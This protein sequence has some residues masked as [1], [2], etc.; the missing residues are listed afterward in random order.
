MAHTYEHGSRGDSAHRVAEPREKR[1]RL[2]AAWILLA[3]FGLIGCDALEYEPS[4]ENVGDAVPPTTG[5]TVD[6]AASETITV[7]GQATL[8]YTLDLG[9]KTFVG[10]EVYLD[11]E[12]FGTSESQTAFSFASTQVPD[13][14]Y[15]LRL[16]AY[17][18]S[19]TG[20]LADQLGA[21]VVVSEVMRT[22]VVD[23]APPSPVRIL[24][25][26]PVA[27]RL[28]L[29]WSAYPRSSFQEYRVYSGRYGQTRLR[30]TLR[31]RDR[32]TWIDSLFV[33]GDVRYE[34]VVAAANGE[35]ASE[36]FVVEAPVPQ[37][38]AFE[39]LGEDGI[40][41]TWSASRFPGNV[42]RYVIERQSTSFGAPWEAAAVTVDGRDTV[43]VDGVGDVFA[44]Q[45]YYRIRTEAADDTA[46]ESGGF[47]AWAEARRAVRD[48]VYLAASDAFVGFQVDE[49]DTRMGL[50][51]LDAQ[52]LDVQAER[53]FGGISYAS[54]FAPRDGTRLFTMEDGVVRERDPHT[55]A[56]VRSLNLNTLLGVEVRPPDP[57]ATE[58]GLIL[59]SRVEL[60][61]PTRYFGRGVVAV[62]F[63]AGT[64]LAQRSGAPAYVTSMID[65]S[66]DGR[67]ALIYDGAPALYR[68]NESG[69]RFERVGSV[70]ETSAFLGQGDRIASLLGSNIAIL[71]TE[72]LATI[73]TFPNTGG[74]RNVLVDPATGYVA[75]Y[76]GAYD[77]Q[78]APLLTVYDP[79]A[80]TE[81]AHLHIAAD[82]F[83]GSY[84]LLNHT[85]WAGGFHRRLGPGE[86]AYV[87][88]LQ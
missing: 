56:V 34:V 76:D 73:R 55:L 30:A 38:L 70:S 8:R 54:V 52:T 62:D 36:E 16:V 67:H 33:G 72:S 26:E 69:Q 4:G 44:A 31:D 23:N 6:L 66:A 3:C 68:L 7:W 24:G 75:T 42:A 63:D 64:V 40:R 77:N 82:A 18:R 74:S 71:D 78:S 41:L 81:V 57:V 61:G 15:T 80:G 5:I 60:Q 19:G 50:V 48:L 28:R 43:I 85:L 45:Y 14:R 79:V 87:G 51:R 83:L 35:V 58:G 86:R 17:A 2:L 84:Q 9:G 1:G 53:P 39:P 65:A 88:R 46:V 25:A 20:S 59:F 37:P 27:G 29:R 22:L 21:E 11:G 10:V 13:G 49:Y 32:T 47:R 12:L